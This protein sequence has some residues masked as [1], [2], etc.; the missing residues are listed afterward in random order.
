MLALSLC[1]PPLVPS[2]FLVQ[3]LFP[4]PLPYIPERG[5]NSAR[6]QCSAPNSQ[7]CQEKVSLRF[8]LFFG[9]LLIFPH[10]LLKAHH[11]WLDQRKDLHKV[12]FATMALEFN[13]TSGRDFLLF[14]VSLIRRWE[15]L[16]LLC[17]QLHNWLQK[18]GAIYWD[19][20]WTDVMCQT[21]C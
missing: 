6:I 18:P 13:Q 9:F 16:G 3:P 12:V 7:Q 19:I 20:Y 10:S 15:R 17:H 21:A 2:G 4:C 14:M 1:H 5:G 11:G 8:S